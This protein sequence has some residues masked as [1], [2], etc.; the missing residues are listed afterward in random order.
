MRSLPASLRA[1][2]PPLSRST[3]SR[4]RAARNSA[5]ARRAAM[6]RAPQDQPQCWCCRYFCHVGCHGQTVSRKFGD[7]PPTLSHPRTPE[8]WDSKQRVAS[9]RPDQVATSAHSVPLTLHSTQSAQSDCLSMA[10]TGRQCHPAVL[11]KM[12]RHANVQAIV[13]SRGCTLML[14]CWLP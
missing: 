9:C 7:S 2:A 4:A 1:L 10:S 11:F 6:I 3:S 5:A 8:K 14:T 13:G 12:L